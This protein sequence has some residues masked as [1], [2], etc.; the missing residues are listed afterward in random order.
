MSN[1]YGRNLFR[2]SAPK[3]TSENRFKKFRKHITDRILAKIEE[4][5]IGQNTKVFCWCI[6]KEYYEGYF[7]FLRK[8]MMDKNFYNDD[9]YKEEM[10]H[11]IRDINQYEEGSDLLIETFKS[12]F[13]SLSTNNW[14]AAFSKINSFVFFCL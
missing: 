11:L 1:G 14:H 5:S 7:I 3:S 10:K 8:Y 6:R 9:S 13:L 12:M 4:K 2:K